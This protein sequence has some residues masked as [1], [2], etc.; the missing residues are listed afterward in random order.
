MGTSEM[1]LSAFAFG[2]FSSNGQI[3]PGLNV[4]PSFVVTPL[5]N[6]VKNQATAAAQSLPDLPITDSSGNPLSAADLITN[7]PNEAI[8]EILSSG[9]TLDP[10]SWDEEFINTVFEGQDVDTAALVSYVETAQ[11]IVPDADMIEMAGISDI[12]DLTGGNVMNLVDLVLATDPA[13]EQMIID[14]LGGDPAAW[15]GLQDTLETALDTVNL[16]D[17]FWTDPSQWDAAA[18]ESKLSS[19]EDLGISSDQISA[20]SS[21]LVQVSQNEILTEGISLDSFTSAFDPCLDVLATARQMVYWPKISEVLNF[22]WTDFGTNLI[23]LA[24][25]GVNCYVIYNQA[26]GKNSSSDQILEYSSY[27]FMGLEKFLRFFDHKAYVMDAKETLV[28]GVKSRIEVL[29]R[30]KNHS[31]LRY[32]IEALEMARFVLNHQFNEFAFEIMDFYNMLVDDVPVVS[33]YAIKTSDFNQYFDQIDGI[34]KMIEIEIANFEKLGGGFL[35]KVLMNQFFPEQN[36]DRLAGDTDTT[37][38][39]TTTENIPIVKKFWQRVVEKANQ[40]ISRVRN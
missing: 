29:E 22:D 38:T 31:Y 33:D 26:N 25:D 21:A 32:S 28:F 8:V 18:I 9:K 6:Q 10:L 36:F 2:I 37:T 1:K 13:L 15:D 39:T 7:M 30:F 14:T 20:V 24:N 27:A 23:S 17:P 3:I 35:E 34:L 19:L 11:N 12:S 4:M 40:I 5:V 16:T